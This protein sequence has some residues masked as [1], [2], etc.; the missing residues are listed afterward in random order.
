MS[1]LI[2]NATLPHTCG[3]CKCVTACVTPYDGS[4]L[5]CKL[6]GYRVDDFS[7]SPSCPLKEVVHCK[8]C[9]N[10]DDAL[11]ERTYHWCCINDRFTTAEHFC[12]DG[13]RR[14]DDV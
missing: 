12:A 10:W 6:T 11:V 13:E 3:G 1:V 14:A 9:S 4:P 5:F 8:D 2:R 7:R